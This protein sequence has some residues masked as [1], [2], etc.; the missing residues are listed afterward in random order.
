MKNVLEKQVKKCIELSPKEY[1]KIIKSIFGEEIEISF[2]SKGIWTGD[3]D[4]KIFYEDICKGLAQYFDVSRVT[5]VHIDDCREISVWIVYE[6]E[7]HLL[8]SSD[9]Y[10]I[11]STIYDSFDEAYKAMEKA[12]KELTPENNDESS[13][14]MSYLSDTSA[15]LYANGENVYVW[16]I[17][18]I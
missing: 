4:G 11:E 15:M 6:E 1:R 17:R 14:E 7:K 16:N 8:I 2:S 18:K 9:G 13:E 3:K 12:Y 10:S 5:D